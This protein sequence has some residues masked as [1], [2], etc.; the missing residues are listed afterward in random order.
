RRVTVAREVEID[1]P[2]VC[3]LLLDHVFIDDTTEVELAH[4]SCCWTGGVVVSGRCEHQPE[5]E[6][7]SG[8]EEDDDPLPAGTIQFA[9]LLGRDQGRASEASPPFS[10]AVHDRLSF[11]ALFAASATAVASEGGDGA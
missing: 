9:L 1:L 4:G 7:D 3:E 5:G 10:F 2:A 6:D 11:L 8:E